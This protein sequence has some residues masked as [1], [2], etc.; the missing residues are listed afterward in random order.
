MQWI[1]SA[2]DLFSDIEN[3]SENV[4]M[5]IPPEVCEAA[6]LNPGDIINIEATDDGKLILTKVNSKH[7]D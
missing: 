1:Y 4:M 3:D 6:N 7:E 2:E 5:N